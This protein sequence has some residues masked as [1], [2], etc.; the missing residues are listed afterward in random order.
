[1]SFLYRNRAFLN[2]K[3]RTI[4]C[5][6]L[7]QPLIDYCS[8]SWYELLSVKLKQK[9]DVIQRRMVRFIYSLHHMEHVGPTH[10]SNLSWLT[11]KDRVNYFKLCHVFKIKTGLAPLYMSKSFIPISSTHSHA[12]RGSCAYN[13]SL[14][15]R[16]ASVPNTFSFTAIKAWNS[17]P[18]HLKAETSERVY[19]SKLRQFLLAKY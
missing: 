14:S 7:I 19:K 12:T 5:S 18:S 9:L 10:F 1:M 15:H 4:L 3:N 6:A 16:S 17:L 13:F 11:I 2:T 8:S